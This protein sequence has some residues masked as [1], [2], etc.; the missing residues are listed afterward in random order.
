MIHPNVVNA[1]DINE[2]SDNCLYVKGSIIGRL[3]MGAVALRK[4]RRNRILVVTE[5]RE[6]GDWPVDQV[7]NSASAARATLGANVVD[8]AVLSRPLSMKME[9]SASGRATGAIDGLEELFA[10]L[11]DA[12]DRYDAVALSSR[13]TALQNTADMLQQYFRGEGPNPWGGVEAALTHAV[14]L[15]FDVPSAHAPTLEEM[16]LRTQE[17]G[18]TDPSK[19]SGGH[20]DEL[21][22]LHAQRPASRAGHHRRARR[23]LE[24]SVLSVEDVSALVVPDGV[25]GLPRSP[26]SRRASP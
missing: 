23:G 8:V 18:Q 21:H 22:V 1:S 6:D 11:R 24:P 26:R 12:R 25:V 17:F 3:L 2:Q 5:A 7:V 19:S 16:A 14:S 20:L 15:A 4:V 13:I 10:L 9:R